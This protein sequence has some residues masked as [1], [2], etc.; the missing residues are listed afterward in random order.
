MHL[1]YN[2]PTTHLQTSFIKSD[3]PN[4][5]N[6]TAPIAPR[7]PPPLRPSRIDPLPQSRRAPLPIALLFRR[8]PSR[9]LLHS[10]PARSYRRF[11]RSGLR[12]CRSLDWRLHRPSSRHPLPV[13]PPNPYRRPSSAATPSPPARPISVAHD[14]AARQSPIATSTDRLSSISSVPPP[15]PR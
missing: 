3:G 15:I 1:P 8:S 13:Q 10:P 2:S 6:P 9:P 4:T 14:H 5:S 7:L 12:L 11:R